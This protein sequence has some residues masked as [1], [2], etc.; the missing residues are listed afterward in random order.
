M[1]ES[2]KTFWSKSQ[3]VKTSRLV[4]FQKMNMR[5]F[6]S[7]RK[8]KVGRLNLDSS[9]VR[10][11]H[12]NQILPRNYSFI[13]CRMGT[14]HPSYNRGSA[15]FSSPR[16]RIKF[17]GRQ[18]STSLS[19]KSM[20]AFPDSRATQSWTVTVIFPVPGRRTETRNFPPRIR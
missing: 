18:M 10:I 14:L 11:I 19:R 17:F 20:P 1:N 9:K 13:N 12:G 8:T 4:L 16:A 3:K 2:F 7:I 5:T 6:T 15:N